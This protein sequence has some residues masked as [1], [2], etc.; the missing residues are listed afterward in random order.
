[1]NRLVITFEPNGDI[2]DIRADVPLKVYWNCP[3]MPNDQVYDY[4]S[5]VKIG[6]EQAIGGL[7]IGGDELRLSLDVDSDQSKQSDANENTKGASHMAKASHDA[8]FLEVRG[9]HAMVEGNESM[10]TVLVSS[11]CDFSGEIEK[12]RDLLSSSEDLRTLLRVKGTKAT[13]QARAKS[14]I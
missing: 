3:H 14:F 8:R 6:V 9:I 4:T 10:I 1:M 12:W 2:T 7:P 5:D 11:D 13:I